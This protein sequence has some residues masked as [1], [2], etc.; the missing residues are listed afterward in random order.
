MVRAIDREF[1]QKRV[2]D[3]LPAHLI[4]IHTHV[5]LDQFKSKQEGACLRSVTWPRRV[6]V[7]RT[8]S[9][10]SL[11]SISLPLVVLDTTPAYS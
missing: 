10:E 2:R 1:H 9:L 4:D 8:P 6:A 3:F 7:A 11:A 5:W